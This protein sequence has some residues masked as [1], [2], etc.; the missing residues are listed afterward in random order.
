[1]SLHPAPESELGVSY[2]PGIPTQV[3]R[4]GVRINTIVED[5]PQEE[6]AP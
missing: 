3:I 1:M 6:I 4:K 2:K 5:A